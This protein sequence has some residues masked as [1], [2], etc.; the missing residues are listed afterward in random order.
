MT[1]TIQSAPTPQENTGVGLP[2]K[3]TDVKAMALI[4]PGKIFDDISRHRVRASIEARAVRGIISG[5]SVVRDGIE[6]ETA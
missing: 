2:D 6:H 4:Y 3:H 5:K 1:D